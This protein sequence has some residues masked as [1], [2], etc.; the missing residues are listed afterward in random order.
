MHWLTGVQ[1]THQK[2]QKSYPWLKLNLLKKQI[3]PPTQKGLIHKLCKKSSPAGQTMDPTAVPGKFLDLYH[4]LIRL[5]LI[6]S[7]TSKVIMWCQTGFKHLE[8]NWQEV[9]IN[10]LLGILINICTFLVLRICTANYVLLCITVYYYMWLR[11]Y[12][13]LGPV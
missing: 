1:P 7:A 2:R 8:L 3:H 5:Q 11:H 12:Y 9:A 10:E 6:S 13:V 4:R